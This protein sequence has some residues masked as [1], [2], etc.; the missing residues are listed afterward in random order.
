MLEGTGLV[1]F[2][3]PSGK[4]GG[5]LREGRV[6]DAELGEGRTE[7]G[8]NPWPGTRSVLLCEGSWG[9]WG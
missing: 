7:L 5:R 2:C 9:S 4:S 8:P 1:A 6:E 3:V